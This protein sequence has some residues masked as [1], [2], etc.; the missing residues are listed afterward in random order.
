[1]PIWNVVLSS[2]RANPYFSTIFS[3]AMYRNK[4]DS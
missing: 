2:R 1:M 4:F 3:T